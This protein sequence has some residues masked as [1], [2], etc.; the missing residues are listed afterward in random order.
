MVA[1]H[2]GYKGGT[3]WEKEDTERKREDQR[4]EE[5]KTKEEIRR[6]GVEK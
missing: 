6:G 2:K 1:R 3:I 5:K 4:I